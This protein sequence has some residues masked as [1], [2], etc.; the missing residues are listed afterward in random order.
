MKTIA[1]MNVTVLEDD[2]GALHFYFD[3]DQP[4]SKTTHLHRVELAQTVKRDGFFKM[5]WTHMGAQFEA[6]FE[7]Q[8]IPAPRAVPKPMLTVVEGD[9]Q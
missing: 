7:E 5:L 3:L 8:Y 1:N 6:F 4:G 2:H 9:N